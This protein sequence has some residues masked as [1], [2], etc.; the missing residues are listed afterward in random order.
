MNRKACNNPNCL[1]DSYKWRRRGIICFS[2]KRN[3]NSDLT[4]HKNQHRCE[5]FRRHPPSSSVKSKNERKN[6]LT[7]T[8]EK[9]QRT[10]GM[11][12][13]KSKTGK[14]NQTG[15][16]SLFGF[17]PFTPSQYCEFIVCGV[18]L[19]KIDSLALR[20]EGILSRERIR[21]ESKFA[22][23]EVSPECAAMHDLAV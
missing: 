11:Q 5:I 15:G 10:Q 20:S 21:A 18:R 22:L 8:H 16:L 19:M 12:R 2:K 4:A 23:W 14:T 13:K 9:M 6:K 3:C 17:G 7:T 1:K